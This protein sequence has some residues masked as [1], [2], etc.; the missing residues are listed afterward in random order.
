MLQSLLS[1]FTAPVFKALQPKPYRCAI[2]LGMD[3]V[4]AASAHAGGPGL[5]LGGVRFTGFALNSRRETLLALSADRRSIAK[6][7]I[8]RNPRKRNDVTAE[9]AIIRTLNERGAHTCPTL[10]DSGT[11]SADALLAAVEGAIAAVIR[12]QARS[13]FGYLV[14]DYVPSVGQVSLPDAFLAL[15]EQ[16]S[17]GVYNGDFKP[18]NLRFDPERGLCFIIDYD[19]ALAVPADLVTAKLPDFLTW[20]DAKEQEWYGQ[21]S[22]FRHFPGLNGDKHV[23]PLLRDG[24]FNLAATTLYR[25]QETTKA[26]GGVYHRISHP[27]VFANG[28]RGIDE[29]AGLLAKVSWTPGERVLD[30][31]CNAGLLSFYLHDQGCQVTGVDLDRPIIQAASV[32]AHIIGKAVRF[33]VCDLDRDPLPGEFDTIMLFSVLH[34]T[35]D[36]PGNAA[37]LAGACRRIF[38]E[39]RLDEHG[40]KPED[41]A[42]RNTTTWSFATVDKLVAYLESIFPG[43]K[44]TANLGAVD[45]HRYLL[46]F[47]KLQ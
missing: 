1:R 12:D 31:G 36:V 25:R 10:H 8:V 44:L 7:E 9:A 23:A 24:A 28:V 26:E 2:D 40:A 15:M 4:L 43:F 34:H 19:Q 18:A 20:C 29:R 30:V 21:P 13:S 22:F 47:E 38:L 37:R 27:T 45:R 5:T 6:I 14:M 17:L 46:Q 41:G 32:L 11:V 33:G 3:K 42:W 16:K 39:C 35:G